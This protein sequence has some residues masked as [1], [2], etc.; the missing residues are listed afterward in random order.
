[1]KDWQATDIVIQAM[2]GMMYT[3]G[4]PDLEP[5]K[6]GG[7]QAQ[8]MG[9]M[10]AFSAALAALCY[11]DETGE[12]Q[13]VDISLHEGIVPVLEYILPAYSYLGAVLK[14]WHNRH[15]FS[16]PAEVYPCADGYACVG[17]SRVWEDLATILET[18][19]LNQER[20]QL[21]HS[22]VHHDVE[23]VGL[24][25]KALASWKKR[26]LFHTGQAWRFSWTYVPT[27]AEL[28]EDPQYVH[29]RFFVEV[30]HPDAGK[31]RYPGYPYRMSESGPELRP[32]PRLGQ[33]TEEVLGGRLSL[34]AGEIA[35]LRQ[36]GAIP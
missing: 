14:R 13:H 32:A 12:G 7:D 30:E 16:F 27:V 25:T 28:L 18:P 23:F 34:G 15:L 20:F 21:N 11:R 29:D 10:N 2:G 26:D 9:G 31:H 6:A 1:Y 35:R 5:I 4:E 36:Q 19:E 24:L 33:H 8:Y 17:A 22:R 3:I